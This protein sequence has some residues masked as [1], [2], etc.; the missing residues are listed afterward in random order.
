MMARRTYRIVMEF[1]CC[2]GETPGKLDGTVKA[3]SHIE[4]QIAADREWLARKGHTETSLLVVDETGHVLYDSKPRQ[5]TQHER[6]LA[7]AHTA[8][9]QLAHWK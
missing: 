6:G 9:M 4:R 1:L 8:H 7:N 2:D 3:R 5:D